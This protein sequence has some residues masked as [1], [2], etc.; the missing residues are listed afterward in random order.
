MSPERTIEEMPPQVGL[1]S[2]WK[3]NFNNLQ[4][5][6]WHDLPCFRSN[7]SWARKRHGCSLH[8]IQNCFRCFRVAR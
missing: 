8:W 3:R 5:S 1:E 2:A 4:S 6:R 7:A